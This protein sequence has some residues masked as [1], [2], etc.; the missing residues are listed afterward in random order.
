MKSSVLSN[1]P[2]CNAILSYDGGLHCDYCG[3]MFEAP[4]NASRQKP[5]VLPSQ[6]TDGFRIRRGPTIPKGQEVS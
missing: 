4:K 6:E 2:N 5:P 3:A 1:C